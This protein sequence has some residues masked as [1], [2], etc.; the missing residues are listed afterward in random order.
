M[1]RALVLSGG[2]GK[3]AYQI[4]VWK[5]LRRLHVSIDIVTGTSVGALN[6]AYVVQKDYL[7]ALLLWKNIDFSQIY[8]KNIEH[9]I[10]T[11]EG[12]KEIAK[13]Y[14]KGIVF[15]GGMNVDRLEELVAKTL[16]EK[17][18]RKSKID[19]GLVTFNLT[20][21]KAESLTKKDIPKGKLK[22][23]LMASATCYPVFKKKEIEAST[24]I[25]GGVYDN[26]PINL[27]LEMGAEEIIAVDLKAV[28]LKQKVKENHADI[29]IISPKN[30]I[31]SFLVFDSKEA[32][33]AFHFGYNDTMKS[34][35]AL[36]GELYTFKKGNIK[37]NY[38]RYQKQFLMNI[39]HI[40]HSNKNKSI[41]EHL[42]SISAFNKIF[43]KPS[44]KGNIQLLQKTIEYLGSLFDFNAEKIYDIRVY[45]KRLL[46]K[47]D[48]VEL[49]P[50]VDIESLVRAKNIKTLLNKQNT[51]KYIYKK[52]ECGLMNKK[53]NKELCGLAL[54]LS[55]E[56]LG[57]LYLYTISNQKK[58]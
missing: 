6:G 9:N 40:F 22:D 54:L 14:T 17:K 30:K 3:G 20:K 25:D 46:E 10:D 13:M 21:L 45:N 24:F 37:S 57:A 58:H 5:A 56:F 27:A 28:G 51:I 33:R 16:H 41:M 39:H 7:K 15:E 43:K 47:L 38:E 8:N 55:K 34:Y 31:N 44:T 29:R 53:I 36:D 35:H 4:G 1:K 26:L 42:L 50:D 11:F 12:K 52:M 19:Y 2:G 32:R 48:K 18:F 23:Y 49:D